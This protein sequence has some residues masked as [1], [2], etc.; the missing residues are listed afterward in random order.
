MKLGK[1]KWARTG[2]ERGGFDE[3]VLKL[4]GP[5]GGAAKRTSKKAKT[6]VSKTGKADS[7]ASG[8][9]EKKSSGISRSEKVTGVSKAEG[10]RLYG[11]WLKM[12]PKN[13]D[14][15]KRVDKASRDRM[16]K[17]MKSPDYGKK[18]IFSKKLKKTM[19]LE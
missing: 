15:I 14:F 6:N 18:F 12:S 9:K 8:A 3:N 4:G 2:T 11:D 5:G 10:E 1:R 7:T 16:K 17:M 19:G 13:K